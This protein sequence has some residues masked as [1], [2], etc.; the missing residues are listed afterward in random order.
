MK[1]RY[2]FKKI[3]GIF[4]TFSLLPTASILFTSCSKIPANTTNPFYSSFEQNDSIA[5][6]N[7]IYENNSGISSLI[8]K[9]DSGPT[10]GY[11]LNSNTDNNHGYGFNG[12]KTFSYKAITNNAK[13]VYFNNY[14][15]RD[16]NIRVGSQTELSYKVFPILG[17][18]TI[19]SVEDCYLSSYVSIDL[20]Y[21]DKNDAKEQLK[22][23][24]LNSDAK[25]QDGYAINA[26]SQGLS[27]TLYSNQ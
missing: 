17:S 7:T 8:T 27:K 20:L 6:E 24:S 22:K 2:S 14:I 9:T 16:L 12:L 21:S 5:C 25:D 18:D 13:N 15:Y 26:H 10:S 1:N 4:A 3:I 19:A 23:L 11:N